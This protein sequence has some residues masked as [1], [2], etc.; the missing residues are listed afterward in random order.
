MLAVFVASL[1]QFSQEY[2]KQKKERAEM[3]KL[4]QLEHQQ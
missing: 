3:E 4:K 1:M 2:A